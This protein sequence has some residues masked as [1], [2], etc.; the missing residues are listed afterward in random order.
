MER[1]QLKCFTEI[2]IYNPERKDLNGMQA[3]IRSTFDV[4]VIEVKQE[5][6]PS[7]HCINH[8]NHR[9]FIYIASASKFNIDDNTRCI[10]N[11]ATWFIEA[12][13]PEWIC[14]DPDHLD[15]Y[16][17]SKPTFDPLSMI[18]AEDI[19]CANMHPNEIINH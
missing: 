6:A 3:A 4:F 8:G 11:A 19:K 14:F 2:I 7:F 12:G 17:I 13:R 10:P 16:D 18:R 1:E 15:F 9:L 5:D